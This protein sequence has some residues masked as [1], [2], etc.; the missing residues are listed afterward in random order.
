MQMLNSILGWI[1][2]YKILD[3]IP[4]DSTL[5]FVIGAAVTI[6]MLRRGWA[7]WKVFLIVLAMGISKELYDLTSRFARIE[8]SLFDVSITISY[9]VIVALIRRIK[10]ILTRREQKSRA[11]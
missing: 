9:C 4:L 5:H 8:D 1:S 11:E 6:F 7:L 10:L 3:F 2:H